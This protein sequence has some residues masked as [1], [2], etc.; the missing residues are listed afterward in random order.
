M[1]IDVLVAYYCFDNLSWPPGKYDALP[2]R[3]KALVRAFLFPLI[4]RKIGH[5]ARSSPRPAQKL[6]WTTSTGTIT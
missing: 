3:E 5:P 1:D 6:A 4:F 2:V